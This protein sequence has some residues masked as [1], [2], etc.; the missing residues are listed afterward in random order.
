MRRF[1]D[2]R[3]WTRFHDPKSLLLALVGEVGEVAE[4]FQWLDAD[5]A[6]EVAR[7]DPLA[8]RV[9]EELA[10]VLLYLVRLAD[11]CGVDLAAAARNKL[12]AAG[13]RYVAGDVRGV[14]PRRDRASATTSERGSAAALDAHRLS[15]DVKDRREVDQAR[16]NLQE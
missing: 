15:G 2:E 10:D 4:L 9:A 3:D 5:A 14:A 8:T 12:T 11:V 16:T 13:D 7:R 6:A 1:T